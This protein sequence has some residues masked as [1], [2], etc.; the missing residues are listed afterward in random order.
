MRYKF[1]K[2]Q[3]A[4]NDFILI[5]DPKESFCDK[6]YKLISKLC[7]RRFG[8]GADGLMLLRP[9]KVN[10]F[11]MLYFNANGYEGTMCGNGGRCLVA[12]A[13][14]QGVINKLKNIKFNAVDGEHI[15]DILDDNSISLKLIDVSK[16]VKK[17]GGYFVETGS[18]HH[19]EYVRGLVDKDVITRGREIRYHDVYSPHGCNVNFIESFDFGRISIRT[20]ER[21]VENETLACGTGSAAA[22]IVHHSEGNVFDTY[23]IQARGGNLK[24][25]FDYEDNCYRNVRLVGPADFVYKGEIEA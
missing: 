3:G 14:K 1:S 18:M 8:I 4:G 11:T 19:V 7:D 20:Y 12:F 24:V 13:K 23:H 10:D 9:S 21:G 5:H 2:Y 25:T 22:A 16:V 15:A 6:D 17:L